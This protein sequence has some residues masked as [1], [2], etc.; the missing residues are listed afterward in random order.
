MR[1][2]AL[3]LL[4]GFAPRSI[5]AATIYLKDKTY[6]EN[7]KIIAEVSGIFHIQREGGYY[8]IIHLYDIINKA[9]VFCI[10]D[11]E[12]AIRYPAC[13]M[14]I[15]GALPGS[16]D[17]LTANEFQAALIWQQRETQ[18]EVTRQLIGIKRA[19]IMQFIFIIVGGTT[20]LIVAN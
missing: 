1:T 9:N 17:S 18:R 5:S 10:I 6:I 13:L 11:D 8:S 3:L 12:G 20:A 19:I 15:P 7:A 16:T 14:A 2:I 4:L